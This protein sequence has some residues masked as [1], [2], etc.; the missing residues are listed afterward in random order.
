MKADE[1]ERRANS[2]SGSI[3]TPRAVFQEL[4]QEGTGSGA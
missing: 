1:V 4:A 2:S 3:S